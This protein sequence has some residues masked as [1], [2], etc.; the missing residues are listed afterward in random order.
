MKYINK[1]YCFNSGNI[2]KT[3]HQF[4]QKNY[5]HSEK[6]NIFLHQNKRSCLLFIYNF[7]FHIAFYRMLITLRFRNLFFA[8]GLVKLI[9]FY[10]YICVILRFILRFIGCLLH[11][12][13]FLFWCIFCNK[14]ELNIVR[15]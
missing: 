9:T 4:L 5:S 15:L 14:L 1:I 2:Y 3:S 13:T 12:F 10:L 11:I 7:A 8:P 6:R